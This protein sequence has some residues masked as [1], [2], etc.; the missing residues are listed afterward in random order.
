MRLQMHPHMPHPTDP[1][2]IPAFVAGP[3]LFV[4]LAALAVAVHDAPTVHAAHSALA[5]R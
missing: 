2:V 5:S 4:G 1:N 3:A